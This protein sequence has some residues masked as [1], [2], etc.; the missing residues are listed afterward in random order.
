M[1]NPLFE[2]PFLKTKRSKKII[3]NSN[4]IR[5]CIKIAFRNNFGPREVPQPEKTHESESHESHI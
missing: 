4:Y 1:E 3:L 5:L 2:V